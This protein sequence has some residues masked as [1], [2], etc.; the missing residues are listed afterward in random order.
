[1]GLGYQES[2]DSA[3]RILEYVSCAAQ[4]RVG[5]QLIHCFRIAVD[6]R[7]SGLQW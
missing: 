2:A 3:E 1:M 5:Q 7:F 6:S 4:V